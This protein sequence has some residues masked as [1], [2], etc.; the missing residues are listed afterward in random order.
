MFW[1][2]KLP[3]WHRT[4]VNSSTRP[5]DSSPAAMRCNYL[6]SAARR[7][8]A[9]RKLPLLPQGVMN[10]AGQSEVERLRSARTKSQ[11]RRRGNNA[12]IPQADQ[13]ELDKWIKANQALCKQSL[14]IGPVDRHRCVMR[15]TQTYGRTCEML[16]FVDAFHTPPN[17]KL[18]ACHR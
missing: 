10:R 14:G 1:L 9:S 3:Y 6:L 7:Q 12:K 16:C 5:W 8:T 17:R 13:V 18:E 15:T 2:T 11:F 4:P